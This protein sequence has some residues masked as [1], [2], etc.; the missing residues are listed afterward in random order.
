[1]HSLD[2]VY[3]I[4]RNVTCECLVNPE[5]KTTALGREYMGTMSTTTDGHTCRPWSEGSSYSDASFPDGSVAAASNYCRNPE[6]G[7]GGPWCHTTGYR[8]KYC[9]VP[10]C[11]GKCIYLGV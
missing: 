7:T 5:C 8:W 11:S 10:L 3:G 6:G 4:L 2:S 9:P 1:M